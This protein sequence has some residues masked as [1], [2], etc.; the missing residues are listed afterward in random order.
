[1]VSCIPGTRAAAQPNAGRLATKIS[2]ETMRHIH[3]PPE[4]I[5]II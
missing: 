2:I 4:L 3:K 5:S 1:M